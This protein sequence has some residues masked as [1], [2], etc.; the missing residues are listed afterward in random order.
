[1]TSC[2]C[3]SCSRIFDL[4]KAQEHYIQRSGLYLGKSYLRCPLC[5]ILLKLKEDKNREILLIK[6]K[7]EDIRKDYMRA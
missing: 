4:E 3:P 6:S 2:K 7:L 5:E 1:M